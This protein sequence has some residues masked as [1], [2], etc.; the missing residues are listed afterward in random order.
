MVLAHKVIYAV[1]NFWYED[2]AVA[3]Q[4]SYR[5]K[6]SITVLQRGKKYDLRRKVICSRCK[7]ERGTPFNVDKTKPYIFRCDRCGH[8]KTIRKLCYKC[9]A[10]AT[11]N[12]AG[13]WICTNGHNGRKKISDIR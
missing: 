3:K 6:L 12:K 13:I 5:K 2:K 4:Y 9:K 11:R 7:T 1:G 10:I 8:T